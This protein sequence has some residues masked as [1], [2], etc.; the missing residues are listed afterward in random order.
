M[1]DSVIF[2]NCSFIAD[3]LAKKTPLNNGVKHIE[4]H[5]LQIRAFLERK[6]HIIL[7]FIE[8]KP[9]ISRGLSRNI[10]IFNFCI[11]RLKFV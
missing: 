10:E 4:T 2:Q 9:S 5:K 7:C 1:I 3:F 8:K 6:V 11:L